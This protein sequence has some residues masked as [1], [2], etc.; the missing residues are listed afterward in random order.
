MSNYD[1]EFSLNERRHMYPSYSYIE[2]HHHYESRMWRLRPL[3]QVEKE[4]SDK[5]CVRGDF[6][7]LST[8][9]NVRSLDFLFQQEEEEEPSCV[10]SK[11]MQQSPSSYCRQPR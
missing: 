5:D 4:E 1:D 9:R 6:S 2:K 8:M 11:F 3:S 10:A 7:S